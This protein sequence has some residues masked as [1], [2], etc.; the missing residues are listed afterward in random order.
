[1]KF[2]PY[3]LRNVM[4]NKL[5]SVF[6]GLSIAVSLFLVTVMYAYVN[7]QDETAVESLKYARIVVTAKQG[8]T[9]PVP[10]AHVDKVSS[11]PGV[12]TVV[13]L[14]WFGGKYKDDKIPFAQFATDPE[15]VFEVFS[16]FTV[17]PE[18]LSA[19][20]KD[21]TG[22][23]VGEKIARKRG[24]KVGDKIVLKGDI[25]PVNLELSIDGI[26]TGPASS[27]Q[28][29][30]WYHYKYLDELLKQARSQM[31]GN[32]GTMFIKAQSPEG[33]AD[34][35][36]QINA[37]FA[38]SESPVRAMT[39]QA[40]RQ[41][42]TEMLGNVRAYI[43]NVALAVVISLVCVAGNAMAMSLRERTR[44][45]AVLKAIGFSRA[46]VLFLVLV[47]AVVI[48]VGGGLVGV[49]TARLLFSFSDVTLSGIP[50]FN[51]FYV[52]WS[53]VTFGLLLAAGV[54]LA[55][56]IVPAWRAAQ[57]SVV[58]GLRRVV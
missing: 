23:V 3:I 4:R 28:E 58:D 56:G 57:I 45:V 53:T 8:L 42:F 26:Y 27:D 31:A 54:G 39:E 38:N 20:Q 32:A 30:L 7:M 19:W 17:P 25:Y 12:K 1:M 48:A 6:T 55:S 35:M 50:G 5:R 24:W 34:L 47:E 46:I 16:E 36:P 9:F 44:E 18:Q 43:R 51:A 21:R 41:M 29:M 2:L 10:I 49:M 22:C 37:R 33:L 13:P 11:I 14:A 15:H 52:P 40:F